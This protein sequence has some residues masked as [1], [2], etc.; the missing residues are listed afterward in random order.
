MNFHPLFRNHYFVQKSFIP[1][2]EAKRLG[3]LYKDY[4]EQSNFGNDEQVELC[5]ASSDF[6]PFWQILVDKNLEIGNLLGKKVMP[7]YT[8]SRM[9]LNG[10]E[11]VPHTD[12]ECCELDVSIHMDGDKPWPIWLD[13][14]NGP[15]SVTLESGDALFYLGNKTVHWREPYDG[16]W[17]VNA[18]LFYV[19]SD[20]PNRHLLFDIT[21]L[22]SRN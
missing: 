14:P 22:A 5:R 20:G 10:A 1:S 8:Y 12:I 15:A 7:S 4:M 3:R 11:L 18:F 2:I 9:Y 6:F 17:Y 13:T 19:F 16:D 21:K